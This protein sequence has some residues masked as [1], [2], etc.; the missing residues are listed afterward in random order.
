MCPLAC[1]VLHSLLLSIGLI[2][3]ARS[4]AHACS[5]RS[6]DRLKQASREGNGMESL[7][8]VYLLCLV[9]QSTATA[10]DLTM[11]SKAKQVE[12][13]VT[14]PLHGRIGGTQPLAADYLNHAFIR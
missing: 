13:K 5:D 12:V 9:R 2:E 4:M 10:D 8:F 3:K 1:P 14:S 7:G 11:E 6:Y